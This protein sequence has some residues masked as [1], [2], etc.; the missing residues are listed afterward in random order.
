VRTDAASL[1][2]EKSGTRKPRG[3]F[4]ANQSPL[5]RCIPYKLISE[6]FPHQ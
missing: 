5:A 2:L 1:K 6:I 4:I 3:S